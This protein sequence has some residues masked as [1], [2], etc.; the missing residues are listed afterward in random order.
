MISKKIQGTLN[1]QLNLELY[2]AYSYLAISAYCSSIAMNGAAK[3]FFLQAQEELI[4]GEK[5]FRY[6]NDQEAEVVLTEIA[7]PE[8]KYDS[9]LSAFKAALGHERSVTNSLNN[10]AGLCLEE[11]D[12]ATH[13]FLQWFITEQIEEEATVSE[14]IDSLKL[15]GNSG[16]GML[17]IDRELGA[18]ASGT[19]GT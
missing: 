9:L 6:L 15:A 8:E 7:R 2:S 5:V 19:S 1:E 3:W 16:E 12:H 18:R 10:L 11:K 14:I 13:I 17:L 4:H